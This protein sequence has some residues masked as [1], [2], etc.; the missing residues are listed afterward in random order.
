[1]SDRLCPVDGAKLV[2]T[3]HY[4]AVVDQC[5]HCRGVWCDKGELETMVE[6]SAR[7]LAK[8]RRNQP[9]R[10]PFTIRD[11]NMLRPGTHR[12][13]PND[14]AGLDHRERHGVAVD[15]CPLCYGIWLDTDEL[16]AIIN[17]TAECL[18]RMGPDV[19]LDTVDL[20]LA[21]EPERA[22]R[23][24]AEQLHKRFYPSDKPADDH[25]LTNIFGNVSDL[26]DIF[27]R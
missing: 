8:L 23:P 11:P 16:Q 15:F 3:E 18:I 13:C 2:E 4:T 7:G 24:T 14:G 26:L 25:E 21:R 10:T 22:T 5:P 27:N 17:L 9:N 19:D 6:M 1:M 20:P 12:S